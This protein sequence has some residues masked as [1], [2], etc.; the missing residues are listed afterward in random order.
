MSS[1]LIIHAT[2][3]HQ[4]GGR[5]LLDALLR[6]AP[7][8]PITALLDSRMALAEGA[9]RGIDIVRV[10]PTPM[11]RLRAERWLAA[12]TGSGDVVL[13]F[14]NLPPLFKLHGWVRV[15]LQNRYLID[16][17]P[18]DNF[19]LKDRLRISVERRWLSGRIGNVDEFIVQ[20]PTMKRL[21]DEKTHGQPL[22]HV[23]PFVTDKRHYS[24]SIGAGVTAR[25]A[26]QGRF[27][28]VSSGEP[29]KNHRTLLQAWC[30]LAEEGLFPSLQVTLDA[31]RFADLC[32]DIDAMR[33]RHGLHVTNLGHVPH[34]EVRALYADADALI[35]PSTLES[36]GLPL[37]EARQAGLPVLASELDYV[38]DVLDP[39][40]AFDPY[41]PYSIARAVKRFCGNQELS[42]PLRDASEFMNCIVKKGKL[43]CES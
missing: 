37:I 29:H 33:A 28:Y 35:F 19:S 21:L 10:K 1:K 15:F 31:T 38:R 39:E 13:C 42:L 4:G 7:G 43:S 26:C 12:N 16:E 30:L 5:T 24:R 36:F 40:A 23:L 25:T 3:V 14:G 34:S 2:N 32:G 9:V 27:V 41:S 18:L 20:T 22:A 17:T 11:A 6:Q 8:G